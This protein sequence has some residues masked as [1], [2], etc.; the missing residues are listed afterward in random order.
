M[1]VREKPTLKQQ[2]FAKAYVQEGNAT[3]A[4]VQAG[5]KVKSREVAAA[6]GKEN[7]QNPLVQQEIEHWTVR[8]ERNIA[9]SLKVI[10]ELRDTCEDPRI[11]LAAGRDLLNRAGVGKQM[12]GKQPV[13][14]V[15]AQMEQL[16]GLNTAQPSEKI[17]DASHNSPCATPETETKPDG[18]GG[19]ETP[20]SE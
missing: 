18:V 13:V 15:F 2:R 11:R 6:I 17:I 19:I 5:Y 16:A 12:E 7:L 10:E 9:P 3:E 8:L 14:A 4:A 20:A 1:A